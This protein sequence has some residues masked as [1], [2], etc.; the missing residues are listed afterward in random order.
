MLNKLIDTFSRVFVGSLFIFSGLVKLNDP[1]GTEI[2]LEE[3]FTVFADSFSPLFSIFIPWALGISL[4]LIVLEIVLG[5]AVLLNYRMR[6]TA[7]VLLVLMI[8]FTGL[9]FFS[10]YTGKVT[11]CGCFGDAIPLTP[12]QSFYK[13]LILMVFVLHLFWHR[14]RFIPSFRTGVNR[15]IVAFAGLLSVLVGWY[16]IEHLPY[17][18][19]RPYKI[20]NSI[21]QNMIAEENPIVEYRFLKDGEEVT[22]EK[23]LMPEDGYE[24]I[25]ATILNEKASTPKITDYQ[26]VDL[27]G[28]D[29]TEE[30]FQGIKLLLLFQ[31]VSK[32]DDESLEAIRELIAFA[33]GK[34]DVM[35]FTSSGPDAFENYRHE[36]QLAVPYYFLDATVLKAMIRSNPGIMLLK[37]GVVVGKWHANDVPEPDELQ[38]KL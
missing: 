34:F 2:K 37:D 1:I 24:Y 12:W 30:S 27:D 29:F 31:D 10:A 32:S 23:Y 4:F 26:V 28:N 5:V 13:D 9:T 3:Y 11:D 16:A 22:S 35:A 38:S 7:V 36:H 8:F 17:I 20:G 21:P 15:T 19:F 18:D 33:P 25:D 14:K 6:Y